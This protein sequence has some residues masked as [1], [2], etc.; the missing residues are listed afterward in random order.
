M[1]EKQSANMK[2]ATTI[3][4]VLLMAATVAEARSWMDKQGR[5]VEAEVVKV[6][7]DRTVVLKT[8]KGKVVTVP[9]DTFELMDV[10]HLD[11]LL[12]RRG[13]GK[14]HPVAWYEMN[15]LFGF[16]IWQDDR[17]WDD[18]TTASAER[19]KMKK[20]SK[21]DFM[22][23]HRA[24]PLG[25]EKILG[26]QV[27]TTAL[28]GGTEYTESLSLVFLN[29]GDPLELKGRKRAPSAEQI[30]D[31]G[32][33]IHDALASRLGK[34]K[35]DSL[36]KGDLRE[37][38]WRWDWN[39]HAIMLSLQE[40]KYVALRIMPVERADRGGRIEKLDDDEL[41]KRI[42]TC[43]ERRDNGDVVIRNIPMVNQG[44]KGYC[45]P[46]TWERY[47]RYIGI[48]VDMYLL[49]LAANTGTGGGTSVQQMIDAA[50][51]II[52]SN[53]RKLREIDSL[54]TMDN[55]SRNIDRGM[56]VMWTLMSSPGFRKAIYE[57]TARRSG[58]EPEEKD[59]GKGSDGHICLIIGYNLQTG[60]IA[61]SDSWGPKY[62]ERWVSLQNLQNATWGAMS[63]IRW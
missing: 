19:M 50:R 32:M 7:P 24:Y 48:P 42:A 36:G 56:P 43:V 63:I 62:A 20:E 3:F 10:E 51:N 25:K 22:E 59:F 44:P 53:G 49:A 1:D 39:E 26:E 15:D 30:E 37:K 13:R 31:C 14:P 5:S 60:E 4:L 23:N 16:E 38:V 57:N 21:T 12:S 58:E 52:S 54:P 33:R 8:E 9:F 2:P 55:L 41:K 18:P 27:F 29:R 46:A 17:L 47:L 6:N 40:G 61:T 45:V 11:Y 28:Y 34:P 35:R